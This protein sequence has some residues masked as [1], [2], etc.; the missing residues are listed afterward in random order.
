MLSCS[1]LGAIFQFRPGLSQPGRFEQCC[2]LR[3][4]DRLAQNLVHGLSVIS[5]LYGIFRGKKSDDFKMDFSFLI[6]F[7]GLE[8]WSK[9]V[10]KKLDTK[11]LMLDDSIYM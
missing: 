11:D 8:L 7:C 1:V 4:R 2:F 3:A 6:R 9:K 10:S 5:I